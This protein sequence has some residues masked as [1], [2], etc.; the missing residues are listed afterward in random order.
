MAR[1]IKLGLDYFP[2]EVDFFEDDKTELISAEFGNKGELVMLRLLSLIYKNGYFYEWNEEKALLLAKRVGNGC[3][4]ALVDEI[5][6]RLA[7]RSFFDER[8]LRSFGVLTSER[9][10]ENY[11]AAVSRRV[12]VEIIQEYCLVCHANYENVIIYSINVNRNSGNDDNNT[13]SKEKKIKVKESIDYKAILDYYLSF[14]NLIKHKK[15][16]SSIKNAIDKAFKQ[17]ELSMED[18]FHII[19]RHSKIVQLTLKDNQ[20]CVRAR[21]LYELF[22]QKAYKADHLICAEY[23]D[24][25]TKYLHYMANANDKNNSPT[26]NLNKNGNSKN[27]KRRAMTYN[28][29]KKYTEEELEAKLLRK[30]SE[31]G[32]VQ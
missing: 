23:L 14:D 32:A 4:G 26:E 15:M 13:Q 21:P 22:G 25:G 7:M 9:I 2:F 12:K 10:Q 27:D 18:A 30:K 3:T 24:D 20:F 29:D 11:L 16:T 6:S 8:V 28:N 17:L 5:V 19:E 31:K 1:P